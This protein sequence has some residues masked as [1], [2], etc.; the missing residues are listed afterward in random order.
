METFREVENATALFFCDWLV[1]LEPFCEG[2]ETLTSICKREG[3]QL[4][5]REQFPSAL[6]IVR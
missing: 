4:S 1:Y 2:K 5:E 3:A 6:R